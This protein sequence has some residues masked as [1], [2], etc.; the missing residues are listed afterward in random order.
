MAASSLSPSLPLSPLITR[1]L[2]F[3]HVTTPCQASS[4]AVRRPPS[5]VRHPSKPRL[6]PTHC[7]LPTSHAAIPRQP[8][9]T[10]LRTHLRNPIQAPPL[11]LR[12]LACN[13]PCLRCVLTCTLTAW[14]AWTACDWLPFCATQSHCRPLPCARAPADILVMP[15]HVDK[16]P[17]TRSPRFSCGDRY[18]DAVLD[19]ITKCWLCWLI[20]PE[21]CRE[22]IYT[23]HVCCLLRILFCAL[24]CLLHS[25]H[26]PLTSSISTF[27]HPNKHTPSSYPALPPQPC[28]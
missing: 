9:P 17:L 10:Y 6:G 5:A 3:F 7:P 16:A 24:F 8:T 27:H 15:C 11:Q 14:T 20:L 22:Y 18:L 23:L 25:L 21:T 4:P 1:P 26:H 2:R 13:L 12:Y 19:S 28:R